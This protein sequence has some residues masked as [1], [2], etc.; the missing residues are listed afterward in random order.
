M[1]LGECLRQFSTLQHAILCVTLGTCFFVFFCLMMMHC[2][3]EKIIPDSVDLIFSLFFSFLDNLDRLGEKDY[4]P[5]EQDILRTRV[6]T[7]GIVEVHF[8][9]KNLNFK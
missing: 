9:F 4:V 3:P 6:K 7:T 8:R 5:M 1:A 2:V